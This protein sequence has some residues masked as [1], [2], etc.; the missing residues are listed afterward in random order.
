M[1]QT[2]PH[3]IG[4]DIEV[5]I[6]Y[7]I[8]KTASQL[9]QIVIN[10]FHRVFYV[11]LTISLSSLGVLDGRKGCFARGHLFSQTIKKKLE[12]CSQ[13][14]SVTLKTVDGSH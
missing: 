6:V 8:P 3:N 12:R 9:Y 14:L 13:I 4:G 1:T 7:R 5:V 10:L 2:A 11:A